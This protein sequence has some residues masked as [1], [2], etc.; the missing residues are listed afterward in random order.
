MCSVV[1]CKLY[2]EDCISS[3]ND[4]GNS[5]DVSISRRQPADIRS[6][7]IGFEIWC[8]SVSYFLLQTGIPLYCLFLC[9]STPRHENGFH[10]HLKGS[11]LDDKYVNAINQLLLSEGDDL[12][13][14]RSVF[15]I[16]GKFSVNGQIIHS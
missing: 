6:C 2:F 7:S 5:K 11:F 4:A 9:C 3:I 14:G 10:G 8:F 12:V 16:V 13:D 1:S 15:N